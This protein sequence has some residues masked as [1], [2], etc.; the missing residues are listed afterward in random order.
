MLDAER[1]AVRGEP[2]ASSEAPGELAALQAELAQKT[3]EIEELRARLGA[4]TRRM[5]EDLRLAANVQRGSLPHIVPPAG[6]ELASEFLPLREIGGDYYDL[7]A[8][9][10]TGVA[11]AIGDVMGKGVAAALLASNLKAS[12]RAQL[13][14][15]GPDACPAQ[16]VERINRLFFEVTPRGR[17]A[18]FFMALFD[19]E[20]GRLD[21]VNAG[22]DH[23]FVVRADGSATELAEGGTVL[24][25]LEKR[26]YERGSLELRDGDTLVFFT[27]GLT[28]RTNERGEP[29]GVE[30]LTE[31]VRR[32][33]ADSPR[34]ILYTL[35]G[36]VQGWSSGLQAEDDMTVVVA[37]TRRALTPS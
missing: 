12:F 19:L 13:Q 21:Y 36:E 14:A 5:E 23:P 10:E 25:L 22:H 37:K 6:L 32:S 17:F 9:G 7:V 16:I 4:V 3:A 31:A 24:G 29:F 18:T 8:L 2:P 15:A 11:L 20:E 26:S 30:R 1:N 27:D 35:L 33:R 28:D 34:I